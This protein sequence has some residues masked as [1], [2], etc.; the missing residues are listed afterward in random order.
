MQS[1]ILNRETEPMMI[2]I[3]RLVREL[4]PFTQCRNLHSLRPQL[5][6]LTQ[7]GEDLFCREP[8]RRSHN[9]IHSRSQYRKR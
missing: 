1:S 5:L 9:V 3:K 8:L 6:R 7:L 2:R 4:K